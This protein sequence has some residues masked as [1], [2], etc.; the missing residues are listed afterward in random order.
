MRT[1]RLQLDPGF[2]AGLGGLLAV[3]VG[4]ALTGFRSEVPQTSVVLIL[5]LTVLVGAL[6]GGRLGG[7]VTAL[8][9]ALSFDFFHTRPYNSL[10]IEKREDVQAALFLLVVGLVIGAPARRQNAAETDAEPGR[11]EV[12]RLH[13]VAE[14]VAG[15]S[16]GAEVVDAA[17]LELIE[18]LRLYR[19][20]YEPTVGPDVVP[21][22]ERS[23]VLLGDVHR[24]AEGG[25][26]LP[27]G[28]V[29]IEVLSGGRPAGRFLLHPRPGVGISLEDRIVAVALVDQV[30]AALAA[31]S[32]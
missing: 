17:R 2:G 18:L 11:R 9:A 19:C 29:A 22:L 16:A 3:L 1:R 6:V 13:R 30:G 32:R 27:T 20:E 26:E 28:G 7:A 8:V 4:A 23:G 31:A 21:H 15:G 5:V 12:R 10:S 24:Y 14:L 25:L